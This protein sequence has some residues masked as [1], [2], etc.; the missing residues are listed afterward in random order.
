MNFKSKGLFISII[1]LISMML[2]CHTVNFLYPRNKNSNSFSNL[3]LSIPNNTI[4]I[5][6]ETIYYDYNDKILHTRR[7]NQPNLETY[8]L[9]LSLLENN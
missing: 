1:I 5:E 2:I 9:S 3:P 8:N 6:Y 4:P 7:Q